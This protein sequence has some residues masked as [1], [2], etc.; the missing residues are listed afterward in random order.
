MSAHDPLEHDRAR[1][2]GCDLA[3]TDRR[4]SILSRAMVLMH[5]RGMFVDV[6]HSATS[7][8]RWCCPLRFAPAKSKAYPGIAASSRDLM[9]EP[10]RIVMIMANLVGGYQF[11]CSCSHAVKPVVLSAAC[12]FTG[13]ARRPQ[14][15]LSGRH[16]HNCNI[17]R[18]MLNTG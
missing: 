11:R 10:S 12:R 3:M 18:A 8:Q 7:K 17:L 1:S 13:S 16:A 5:R 9:A 6:C 2:Q 4:F 14:H 15:A